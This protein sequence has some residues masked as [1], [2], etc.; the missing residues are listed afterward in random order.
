MDQRTIK[1]RSGSL[2]KT[3]QLLSLI[4]GYS[5]I[6]FCQNT[7]IKE[8]R[9][10]DATVTFNDNTERAVLLMNISN[11]S[12]LL[13]ANGYQSWYSYKNLDNISVKSLA[14][15]ASANW[16]GFFTAIWLGN[17]L[18]Y[19]AEAEGPGNSEPTAL[20]TR[21]YPEGVGAIGINALFGVVGMAVANVFSPVNIS[22]GYSLSG[23][24][25][26]KLEKWQDFKS[27]MQGVGRRSQNRFH[28]QIQT[29]ILSQRVLHTYQKYLLDYS[30]VYYRQVSYFNVLRKLEANYAVYNNLR[31]G[32]ALIHQ[33]EPSISGSSP[34]GEYAPVSMKIKYNAVGYYGTVAYA[35]VPKEKL[36]A[37]ELVIGAG[38]GS[39]SSDLEF[40]V[41]N[42]SV[43]S[44]SGNYTSLT[45]FAE[46]HVYL[47]DFFSLSLNADYCNSP[48]QA[49]PAIEELY[50]N[51]E[52]V[53]FGNSSFGFGLGYHF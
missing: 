38:L 37:L 50:I 15:P 17:F 26:N 12:L 47:S 28:L 18:F 22:T 19:R 31:L 43:Y 27:E 20:M 2:K 35:I 3:L 39:L 30:G 21:D 25:E 13:L 14:S 5:T 53:T 8:Y 23:D 4:L 40:L 1:F 32:L 10:N 16:A 36:T 9:Y 7:I 45:I 51:E 48:E 49:I 44:F 41:L 29:G 11:D 34:Q 6:A 33:G 24:E 46:L 52:K 42:K